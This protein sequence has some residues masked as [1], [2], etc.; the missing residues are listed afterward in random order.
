MRPLGPPR[1]DAFHRKRA[2][3][4]G[5]QRLMDL[6]CAIKFSSSRNPTVEQARRQGRWVRDG[7]L[8]QF[9][10]GAR[11]RPDSIDKVC[12]CAPVRG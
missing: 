1:T 8:D 3:L 4:E 11:D 6:H 7:F 12:P 2:P 9:C 10:I 5:A